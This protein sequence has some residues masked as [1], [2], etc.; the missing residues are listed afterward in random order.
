LSYLG[1]YAADRDATLRALFIE[2]AR[3]FPERR[4]VIGGS[5]YGANFPWQ[6]NVYLMSHVPA[7]SHPAFYCSARL[8]LNVTRRAMLQNGYC[9]SGR[10]FEA[11]ACGAPLL[12][13]AW[14]GVDEFFAPGEEIL[15]ARSTRDVVAALS[16]PPEELLR[17]GRAARE[18]TLEFH[19]ADVR[20]RELDNILS[21][22]GQKQSIAVAEVN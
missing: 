15:I 21:S 1:T 14:P 9:P 5:G 11:A 6:P 2:P 8:N 12:S 4:F 10:L 22:R 19:T 7:A 17:V 16:L 18:R 3:L 20:A 13:D